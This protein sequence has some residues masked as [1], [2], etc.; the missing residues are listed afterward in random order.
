MLRCTEFRT[1]R[2]MSRMSMFLSAGC[3]VAACA[4]TSFARAAPDAAQRVG[5]PPAQILLAQSFGPP[6]SI[7]GAAPQ[8]EDVAAL[9]VRI[10]RLEN[11]VR[12][13]N[14]Q[15]EQL[16]FDQHRLQDALQKFQQD[17]DF[18]F[19]DAAH[20]KGAPRS[21][22]AKRSDAGDPAAPE[23]EQAEAL[24][25]QSGRR[26]DAFDP[27]AHPDAPGAPHAIG[28]LSDGVAQRTV[29]DRPPA[30]RDPG[31]PLQLDNGPQASPPP[32]APAPERQAALGTG[33]DAIMA[34]GAPADPRMEYDLALVSF[35][36]GQFDQAEKGFRSY[37]EKHPKDRSAPDAVY[38]LGE[39]YWRLG[40]TREAAQQYLKISTDY[41]KSPHAPDA[42]L[43]LGLSLDKLGS[44]DQAC[45]SFQQVARKYP[46]A[47]ASVRGAVE[48]S[49]KKDQC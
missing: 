12:S 20:A 47:P 7:P 39:S 32:T 26:D 46:N 45:A 10:D 15:I 14:G 29:Q 37:L 23:A 11:Q 27:F 31:G 30:A 34:S 33:I 28:S 19:Q 4:A 21:V 42:L 49:V 16:N 24:P 9:L 25:P 40:K 6:D 5:G 38:Y 8:G 17:V 13:L 2:R 35:K 3:L 43:K 1:E 18:R 48:K 22:P 41:A 36:N 44:R